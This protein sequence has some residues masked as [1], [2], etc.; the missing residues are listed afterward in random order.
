MS[1]GQSREVDL[2]LLADYVGGALEGTPEEATVARLI[3][4]DD[5]WAGAHEALLVAS[6]AVTADLADWGAASETMPADVT[7]RI[8]TAL[9]DAARVPSA[10]PATESESAPD[11]PADP[12]G[13][14]AAGTDEST[15]RRLTVVPGGRSGS[16][17]RAAVRSR[18]MR[19]WAAP[20]AIAAGVVAF[21]SFGVAQLGG[22]NTSTQDTSAAGGAERAT[23]AAPD[24]NGPF[25][26]TEGAGPQR[27]ASG[28]DYDPTTLRS[29]LDA[30]DR[31]T[32]ST[33]PD[34]A[35]GPDQAS[36]PTGPEP[37]AAPGLEGLSGEAAL[38][39][40]FDAVAGEHARGPVAV[41]LVDYAAFQ[42]TP[43]LVVLFTDSGG[44]RWVWVA[45]PA[46][47]QPGSGADTRYRASVG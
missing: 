21:A 39:T 26:A 33:T 2:D 38:L 9:A 1:T 34:S 8:S 6:G 27:L 28:I 41:D 46:C 13:T 29:I 24:V 37:L 42:G 35:A 22:N 10:R 23:A 36:P 19:R 30:T 43:A 18:R 14:P 44:Q 20:A 47:G 40:C 11:E 25:A 15:N 7:A 45:G 3:A 12:V 4:D 17:D 31:T 16:G 32:L 5:R